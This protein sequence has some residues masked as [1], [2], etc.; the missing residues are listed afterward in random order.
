M[1]TAAI[2]CT[3]KELKRVFPQ[4]DSF[5]GK[6]QVYG[7]AEEAALTDFHDSSVDCYYAHGTGLVTRLFWDGAEVDQIA[8]NTTETTEVKVAITPDLTSIDVDDASSS[9]FGVGDIIKIGSEYMKV[10]ALTDSDTLGVAAASRGLFNSAAQHH[11]VDT[12]V[13]KIIDADADLGDSSSAGQDALGFMYDSGLDLCLLITDGTNPN[14]YLVEAGED[15][16]KLVTQFR[17][18]ASR[19]L[20][21]MLDPNMPKEALKDK[22]GNFDYIIIRSTALI[23][24]NFMI[25]SHDPN[26]ELASALMEEANNNIE[27]I[28]QGK[29]A[30]SWQVSRDSSQ[31]IVRDVTYTSGKIRPVDT[32]GEWS[33]T[34]DLIKVKIGT[35]G[36]LGTATYNVYI[37]DGDGLKNQQVITNAVING[38]YQSLAGGL[39][40]RFAGSTDS[41][42][43]TANNEWEIEVFGRNEVVDVS[44]GKAVKMTRTGRA[45]YKRKYN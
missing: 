24:A 29:A 13:Y 27:N 23:A 1:A 39:E 40:I 8:Y 20:D 4:L 6:K 19:Y 42:T 37:K 3:H 5:D 41:S 14:D 33:G 45:S 16:T 12:N 31:G 10:T 30:L 2:Y 43:A 22:E 38:D 7:W 44:E 35:G 18:D 36:V 21:S 32:R 11:P 28:N 17:T 15:F 34:Y 9:N 25:K 26:S